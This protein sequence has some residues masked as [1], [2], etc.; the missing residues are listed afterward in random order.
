M[1]IEHYFLARTTAGRT[2][3]IIV[4]E[5]GAE[6]GTDMLRGML[7]GFLLACSEV[8]GWDATLHE[9]NELARASRIPAEPQP[10][11][12]SIVRGEQVA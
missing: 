2:A 8:I 9:V 10:P 3:V 11:R 4:D 5:H 6:I 1:A 12:L 7:G